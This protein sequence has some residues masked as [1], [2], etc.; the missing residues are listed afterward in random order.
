MVG[1]HAAAGQHDEPRVWQ[2]VSQRH[3]GAGGLLALVAQQHVLPEAVA[4]GA[5]DAGGNPDERVHAALGVA[6]HRGFPGKHQAVG[7]LI[8]GVH[9]VGDF[10]AG[11]R[12]VG[13]HGFQQ[14]RGDDDAGAK[15]VA[16]LDDAALENRQL[17]E[18]HL[19]AQVAAGDHD[20][21]GRV[22]DGVDVADG[23]LVLDLGDDL[24]LAFE[25]LHRLAQLTDVG[26]IPHERSG[27]VVRAALDGEG[28]VLVIL[29]RQGG[30]IQA[31]ARQVDV[32]ARAHRPRRFHITEHAVRLD[33]VDAHQQGAVVHD[34]GVTHGDVAHQSLVIDRRGKR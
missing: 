25:C 22:D 9:H 20:D 13:D 17:L 3:G 11:R 23:F 16:A 30:Q 31:H 7:L 2:R 33:D 34:E 15:L 14:L 18:L 32:T 21:V 19:R 10:R 28:K 24:R 29:F 4:A 1:Q 26:G 12:G 6:A 27:D 5:L 8:G